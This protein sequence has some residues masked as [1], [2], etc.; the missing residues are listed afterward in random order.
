MFSNVFTVI[1][2]RVIVADVN[3]SEL[4]EDYRVGKA[5]AIL[6]ARVFSNEKAPESN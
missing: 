3:E 4:Y 1:A 5:S 6:P 2:L